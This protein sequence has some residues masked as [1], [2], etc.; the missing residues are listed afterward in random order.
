MAG[1]LR[2]AIPFFLDAR[3]IDAIIE[4]QAAIVGTDQ[5][6]DGK[7][8]GDTTQAVQKGQDN[9]SGLK[10]VNKSDRAAGFIRKRA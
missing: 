10:I 5:P 4:A 9:F 3:Q 2:Y 6:K 7:P 8:S 1:L